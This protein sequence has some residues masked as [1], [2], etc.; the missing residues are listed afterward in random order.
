MTHDRH[1]RVVLLVGT[2]KGLFRLVSD[3]KREQWSIDGP[4]IEG[5]EILHA[6]IDPRQPNLAY[7]AVRHTIWGAHV[8]HSQDAGKTWE[9]LSAAP[10][11]EVG[12]H[13]ESLRA[14]WF[15]AP[16][17]ESEPDTLYAGIDPAGLFVSH[18]RGTSWEPV[19]SLNE[20]PTR[21]TWEPAKGGFSLHSIVQC[22]QLPDRLYAAV[23]AGGAYRSDDRGAS[24]YPINRNVRAENKPQRFLESGQNI[25]RL[26]AHPTQP[27][28]LYRQCYNGMYRS[29]DG[30]LN[31]VEI[32]EGLPSDFGYA[33]ATEA[34]DPD[35]VY[36]LPI[37]SNHM[38][39]MPEGRM[40]VYRSADGGTTWQ[41]LTQ[42]LPQEHVYASVLREAMDLDNLPTCGVYF[43]TTSGHVFASNDQGQHWQCLAA[44]LPRVL[45]VEAMVV[46]ADE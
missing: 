37:A 42:G 45:S 38:R 10:Q 15:L 40:R 23:S 35:V 21:K 19:S 43:G 46:D 30:G 8:Y 41:A 13:K 34:A 20:H 12:L 22:E 5:H 28:R 36:V 16:G 39:T 26:V 17:L 14:I 24:W 18:D 32:S 2:A 29:D 33:I 3:A 11:H 1:S 44:F 25:H 31:W 9:S 27:D 7:A 6:W 4:L